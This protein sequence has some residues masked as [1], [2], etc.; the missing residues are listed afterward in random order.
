M[1][2][3]QSDEQRTG[4]VESLVV[5]VVVLVLAQG[6]VPT[7]G[8]DFRTSVLHPTRLAPEIQLTSD[9]DEFRLSRLRGQIIA[10]SFGYTFCPD[11]CPTVLGKLARARAQLGR[12]ASGVRVVFVALDPARDTPDRLLAHMA[13]FD[14]TFIGVTGTSRELARVQHAY[15][16][17][18]QPRQRRDGSAATLID[19]SA[20]IYVIDQ[21]GRLRL[22][23]T[24]A[25]PVDDMTHD[26]RLLA[27]TAQS[28]R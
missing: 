27:E 1:K 22:M 9:G 8:E 19:H 23:F 10:L 12:I 21:D 17:I 13:A 15:G 6:P 7:M 28:S 16:V 25:T 14:A 4:R 26:L 3:F 11:V 24:A 18:A 5:L 2:R 20:P